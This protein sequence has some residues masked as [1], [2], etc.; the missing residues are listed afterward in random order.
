MYTVLFTIAIGILLGVVS[1]KYRQLVLD[2]EKSMSWTVS[3]LILLF[4][5]SI[6]SDQSILQNLSSFGKPALVISFMGIL[7]S[8]LFSL[9]Y[10]FFFNKQMAPREAEGQPSMRS[11]GIQLGKVLLHSMK[12]PSILLLGILVGLSGLLSVSLGSLSYWVLCALVFQV[13]LS[14]GSRPDFIDIIHSVRPRTLL[15][16]LFTIF[17]TLTFTALAAF[18]LSESVRD[19]LTVGSGFGYYSLSSFIILDLKSATIGQQ[20]AIQL[21]SL[22]LIIN[23]IRELVALVLCTP[24]ALSGRG[25]T[26]IS[27]AGINSMDV[28]LPMIVNQR[29]S[30]RLMPAA[31]IHGI[32]LEI[33]VP[34]ILSVLCS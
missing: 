11:S 19:V 28:C 18:L 7:G 31:V 24:V 23:M 1:R 25:Y 17:G 34:L 29:T 15:L 32:M 10:E 13:G 12:L 30:A 22:S 26:A 6:G 16:P 2:T 33:S 20:A 27:L 4:G 5:H 8:I 3:F 14:L 9:V 21:A